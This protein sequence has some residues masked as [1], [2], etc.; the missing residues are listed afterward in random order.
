VYFRIIHGNIDLLIRCLLNL[1][2]G[3]MLN[4]L[5]AAFTLFSLDKDLHV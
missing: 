5:I 2:E 1:D 3:V 4:A